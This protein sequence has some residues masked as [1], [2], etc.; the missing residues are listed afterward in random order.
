MSQP[1]AGLRSAHRKQEL[2]EHCLGRFRRWWR[3]ARDRLRPRSFRPRTRG[4]VGGRQAGLET[5]RPWGPAAAAPTPAEWSP[6][7]PLHQTWLTRQ[8]TLAALRALI[9][10][11]PRP[12]FPTAHSR[13]DGPGRAGLIYDW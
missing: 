10:W 9:V 1:I 13:D 3:T 4:W 12:A 11:S 8:S 2:A 6:R 7:S 5:P